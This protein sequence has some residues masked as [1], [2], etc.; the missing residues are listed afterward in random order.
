MHDDL[1]TIPRW[2]ATGDIASLDTVAPHW[3]VLVVDDEEQVHAVTQLALEGATFAGRPLHLLSAYSAAEARAILRAEPDIALVLLDVVMETDTAGLSLVR[4]IRRDLGNTLVRII[5]RTGHPGHA[6]ERRVILDYDINDYR[7]KTELTSERLFS[8][9]VAALRCHDQVQTIARLLGDVK[10]AHRATAH[11]LADL[12]EHRDTDTGA[13]IRRVHD[14][15]HALAARLAEA[16]HYGDTLTPSFV[17]AIGL[18]S[19]LHDV[20]KVAIP[21]SILRKPGRLDPGEWEVMKTHTS[22]GGDLLR[23]TAAMVGSGDIHLSM[24]AAIARHHHERF[25][26]SGYPDALKGEDIPLAARITAVAD[27]FDALLSPRPYKEAWT[28]ERALA[29]MAEERGRHFDPLVLDAFFDIV[30]P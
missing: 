26:G 8:S 28:R 1:L 25:D 9:V 16:G 29:V 18:A 17:E 2:N 27:V 7:T 11:A 12:A 23:R 6:P 15:S 21:D 13:H 10:M 30:I 24:A 20:G 5:L 3:L 14:L 22:A 19:I 4:W